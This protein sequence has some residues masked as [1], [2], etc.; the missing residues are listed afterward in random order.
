MYE[1]FLVLLFSLIKLLQVTK[2]KSP[3]P[4][5]NKPR[6]HPFIEQVGVLAKVSWQ[7][8]CHFN[9]FCRCIECRYKEGCL[10]N[11]VWLKISLSGMSL[12]LK[13]CADEQAVLGVSA[14]K[15]WNEIKETHMATLHD[16]TNVKIT[17]AERNEVN[18][19]P[20]HM[21]LNYLSNKTKQVGI[22]MYVLGMQMK[23]NFWESDNI[24]SWLHCIKIQIENLSCF[25]LD[26]VILKGKKHRWR[27]AHTSMMK[28]TRGNGNQFKHLRDKWAA[29][30]EKYFL[31]FSSNADWSACASAQSDQSLRYPHEE[32][33]HSWLSKKRQVNILIRLREWAGRTCPIVRFPTLRFNYV[34]HWANIGFFPW[35]IHWRMK[36]FQCYTGFCFIV[37]SPKVKSVMSGLFP[38]TE[39]CFFS[40]SKV[41]RIWQILPRLF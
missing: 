17:S 26:Y 31:T 34:T 6:L 13:E 28:G 39:E 15:Q 7:S 33:A 29:T 4:F 18:L 16:R 38:R 8:N 11:L 20:I 30:S 23:L 24:N 37:L 35:E 14:I 12:S 19:C 10:Y 3:A 41:I 9:E 27:N 22:A 36:V 1:G 25:A 40:S 21:I 2:C 5:W 32:T